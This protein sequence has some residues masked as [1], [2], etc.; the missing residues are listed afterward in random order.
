MNWLTTVHEPFLVLSPQM[1][2][3]NTH[4]QYNDS[5]EQD[6]KAGSQEMCNHDYLGL[7]S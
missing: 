6:F 3:H 1:S 2:Q 7:I 4:K 5:P